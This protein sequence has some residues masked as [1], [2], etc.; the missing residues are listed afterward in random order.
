M[1]WNRHLRNTAAAGALAIPLLLSGC[2]LFG[3]SPSAQIDPPPSDVEAQML[4]SLESSGQ[5]SLET[6]D[7]LSTVYLKNE[8][9]LLAPVSLHL[10]KGDEAGKLNRMLE[11]L[12]EGGPYQG[13]V[14]SGF[15]AVLPE[16]TEVKAVTVKS[17]EKLAIVEFNQSFGSYAAAD[18]RKILEAVTWT[19]LGNQDIENVQLWMDGAKLNE[20][21]VNK[22]PLDR[23]LN[24]TLG[25]NLEL[26]DG[27]SLSQTRP[28]TV[29]FS[30]ST[31]D[32]VQ[33]FVPVTRFVSAENNPVTGALKELIEGPQRGDGLMGVLTDNTVLKALELSEDGIITVS[34]ED[35]MFEP[36]EKPPAQMLQSLVLTVTEN[37]RDKKVRIWL[38][39]QKD[40]IGMDNQQYGEPVLRPETINEIPL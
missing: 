19:L 15:S 21:P 20:M 31:P 38:N 23:P 26:G 13:A 34:L 5:T 36:G 10:P 18:E 30:A 40:V 1:R 35:D 2:S 33:Y 9:G 16:G 17:D 39:G 6:E 22:T 25:I 8:Q 12:V 4:E 27:A 7:T 3:V 32:G 14:P 29:F 11:M 24:R 37:A 28:V